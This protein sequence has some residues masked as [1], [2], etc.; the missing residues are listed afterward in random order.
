MVWGTGARESHQICHL[1]LVD[2]SDSAGM[3]GD[4][5]GARFQQVIHIN[6]YSVLGHALCNIMNFFMA[7]D[8]RNVRYPEKFWKAVSKQRESDN[9]H[10]HGGLLHL[11]K[12]WGRA[13]K[14]RA[15]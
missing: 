11:L 5:C 7:A 4:K 6:I 13:W 10:R 3:I 9:L 1:Y 8:A 2:V 12:A 14:L 15:I